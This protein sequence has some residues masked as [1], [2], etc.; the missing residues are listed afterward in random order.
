M[1]ARGRALTQSEVFKAAF[2]SEDESAKNFDGFAEKLFCLVHD[3]G[4]DYQ[5]VEKTLMNIVNIIFEGFKEI[6]YSVNSHEGFDFWDA[7]YISKDEYLNYKSER[8][9]EINQIFFVLQK[10]DNPFEEFDK[11]LPEYVKRQRDGGILNCLVKNSGL[12]QNIRALF[13]SYLIALPIESESLKEW[14]RV[15]SNLIWNSSDV[16][17]AIKTI[18]KLKGNATRILEFLS[19]D[20][21]IES[22]LNQENDGEIKTALRQYKE[23]KIKA[24]V[25]LK[26]EIT[27]EDIER[28]ENLEILKGK[29]TVLLDIDGARNGKFNEY[30]DILAAL[31]NECNESETNTGT[32]FTLTL[33]PYY[34][35]VLPETWIPVKFTDPETAKGLLYNSMAG[36]FKEYAYDVIAGNHRKKT[37]DNSPYWV[38]TLCGEYGERLIKATCSDNEGF[39]SKYWD[40]LPVLWSKYGCTW[41]SYNNVVLSERN[42]YISKLLTIEEFQLTNTNYNVIDNGLPYFKE[43]NVLLK[44]EEKYHFRTED[45]IPEKIFLL[46]KDDKEIVSPETGTHYCVNIK[47]FQSVVEETRIVI[48]KAQKEGFSF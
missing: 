35:K 7:T 41:H 32:K 31:W 5:I 29:I 26:N 17:Y 34:M 36:T 4:N 28:A 33:L 20:K 39:V 12:T 23:E 44:F 46:D 3:Y 10:S 11:A 13:F 38:R 1:N 6:R 27:R 22:E 45:W 9:D 15:C 48:E 30:C 2:F 21:G 42:E 18:Y 25:I 47:D 24:S 43:R 16:V 19:E 14:M 37:T 8:K 40:S